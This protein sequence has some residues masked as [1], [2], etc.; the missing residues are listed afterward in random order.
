SSYHNSSESL[1]ETVTTVSTY[2]SSDIMTHE[3]SSMI[4]LPHSTISSK[5]R[6]TYY[7]AQ[8]KT[9]STV[10]EVLKGERK[11]FEQEWNAYVI[12][13]SG[14]M[15]MNLINKNARELIFHLHGHS[16]WVLGSGEG[17]DTLLHLSRNDTIPIKR[18]TVSVPALG[19]TLIRFKIN[20]P[21]VWTFECPIVW[22]SNTGMMG[23]FI[24]LPQKFRTLTPSDQWCKLCEGYDQ[25]SQ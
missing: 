5:T 23:Q 7:Y 8:N 22:H 3:N 2:N 1:D 4:Q 25:L 20:N 14:V 9:T 6:G 10:Y 16:F 11:E 19:W 24:E 21:G 15:D 18:D 17:N 12:K 13:T